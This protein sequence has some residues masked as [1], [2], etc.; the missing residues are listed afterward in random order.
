MKYLR[1]ILI[2]LLLLTPFN[3][4]AAVAYDTSANIASAASASPQ[5]VSI[6]IGAANEWLICSVAFPNGTSVSAFTYNSVALTNIGSGTNTA[7]Q[8]FYLYSLYNPSTGANTLSITPSGSEFQNVTC[9][10]YSG[11]GA[12][13]DSITTTTYAGGVTTKT[14]STVVVGTGA[15]FIGV[16]NGNRSNTTASGQTTRQSATANIE[17]TLADTNGTVSPGSNSMSWTSTAEPAGGANTPMF[18]VSIAPPTAVVVKAPF[19]LAF[20]W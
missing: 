15:W 6:T 5:T 10:A 3:A 1:Y 12:T 11:G 19:F 18:G 14:A 9:A 16:A 7:G 8:K 13:L 17:M 2:S 20:W 4:S